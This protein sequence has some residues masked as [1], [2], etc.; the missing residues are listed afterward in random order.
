MRDQP[1]GRVDLAM[2]RSGETANDRK[3]RLPGEVRG[4]MKRRGRDAIPDARNARF[5]PALLAL[6]RESN[7]GFGQRDAT[8]RNELP[9]G[10]H[11]FQIAVPTRIEVWTG[12]SERERPHLW[13]SRIRATERNRQYRCA[14]Y[15]T[16]KE[17]RAWKSKICGRSTLASGGTEPPLASRADAIDRHQTAGTRGNAGGPT[18][19]QCLSG[20]RAD[21]ALAY[22][23]NGLS[24]IDGEI[25]RTE[26]RCDLY[27]ELNAMRSIEGRSNL[28]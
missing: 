10:S 2:R 20:Q 4:W 21:A 14:R 7:P 9:C 28:S 17:A 27:G 6:G 3:P 11:V 24:V 19:P 15:F 23:R 25:F 5:A 18:M 26:N 13:S 22:W 12:S 16:R 8:A 1:L